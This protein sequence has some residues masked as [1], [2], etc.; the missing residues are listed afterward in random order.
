[1]SDFPPQT[2]VRFKASNFMK[3]TA[4]EIVPQPGENVITIAG[5]NGA[6]K[7]SVLEGI[8]DTFR[9]A[10][11]FPEQPVH[12]GAKKAE[13]MIETEDLIITR[14]I[15][16]KGHSLTVRNKADAKN[17]YASPQDVLNAFFGEIGFDPASFNRQKPADQLAQLQE[18][19]GLDFSEIETK[20]AE[21]YTLRTEVGRQ[22]EVAKG[23]YANLPTIVDAPETEVNVA[24]LTE[25]LQVAQATNQQ[26]R[27][28]ET[29][30]QNAS[31]FVA[32]KKEVIRKLENDLTAERE[33]LANAEAQIVTLDETLDLFPSVDES[34]II[35]G[36]AGAQQVNAKIASN[37]KKD[38]LLEQITTLSKTYDEHTAAIEF[39]DVKKKEAIANAEF[40]VPGL[41]FSAKGVTLNNKP[42]EQA[43][44][45]EKIRV[46]V[47]M[48]MALNPKLKVILIRDASLLDNDSFAIVNAMARQYGYQV[49]ME[50]VTRTEEEEAGMTVVIEA[51]E[52]KP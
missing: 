36:L 19:L 20:R 15:T 14:S 2:I 21:F 50:L 16:E 39:I 30:R 44:Q 29:R 46:S 22:V 33:Y 17:K 6:G 32:R 35:A 43:S 24:D 31:D 13:L 41:G 1:M 38:A 37:K 8:E 27:L 5:R 12:E 40:P 26:R 34:V 45:A 7:T 28:L 3:L 48:G 49:W 9:G 25:Q 10:V 51:G 18:L 11:A 42:F 4:V 47:A 23:A 52:V